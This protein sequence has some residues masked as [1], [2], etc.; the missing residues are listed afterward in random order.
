MTSQGCTDLVPPLPP[1]KQRVK[2]QDWGLTVELS[3]ALK[4]LVAF[5]GTLEK[6]EGNTLGSPLNLWS[7][8]LRFLTE[9][10]P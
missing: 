8:L 7:L 6:G 2:W 3:Q 1:P 10:M 5:L 4:P 9:S